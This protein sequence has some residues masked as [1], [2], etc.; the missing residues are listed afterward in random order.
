MRKNEEL[1]DLLEHLAGMPRAFREHDRVELREWAELLRAFPRACGKEFREFVELS[2]EREGETVAGLVRRMRKQ[3]EGREDEGLARSLGRARSRDLKAVLLELGER[4]GRTVAERR[5][6]LLELAGLAGVG[7]A[8]GGDGEGRAGA[9]GD[10]IEELA[11]AYLVV[12]GGL[13]MLGMAELRERVEGL[14]GGV[15]EATLKDVAERLGLDGSGAASEVKR[16][17]VRQLEDEKVR[18]ARRGV[19]RGQW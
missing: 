10:R 13:N 6:R 19:I 9:D 1:A 4:A 16:R 18:L 7:E 3:I 2:L 17:L 11:G 14:L 12:K 8:D 5:A 15:D